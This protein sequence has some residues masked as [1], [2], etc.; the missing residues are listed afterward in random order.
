M[1]V[2]PERPE[3]PART[4]KLFRNGRNQALRIPR[5]FEFAVDEVVIYKDVDRLIVEPVTQPP[6][7]ATVLATLKPLTVDFPEI[8]DPVADPEDLL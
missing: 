3:L 6:T 8:P 7:L 5:A 4:A 2:H 1:S